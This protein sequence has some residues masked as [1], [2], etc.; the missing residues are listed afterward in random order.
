MNFQTKQHSPYPYFH[1]I[2]NKKKRQLP[3][4]KTS[5]L[6]LPFLHISN[7]LRLLSHTKYLDIIKEPPVGCTDSPLFL[8]DSNSGILVYSNT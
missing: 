2:M 3:K 7:R 6:P 1:G 5:V 8:L 4:N